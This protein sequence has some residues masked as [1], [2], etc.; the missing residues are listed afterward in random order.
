MK[1][2]IAQAG[3]R[4]ALGVGAL[5]LIIV[6]LGFLTTALWMYLSLISEPMY[7]ALIIG[8]GYFGLGLI[9]LAV[10][11]HRS[12]HSAPPH[13]RPAPPTESVAN[14]QTLVEAFISGMSAGS[15]AKRK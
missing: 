3:R 6:G 8:G 14:A 13:A 2:D 15:R 5:T 1:Y 7:A 12:P 4:A 9:L 11:T 10:S